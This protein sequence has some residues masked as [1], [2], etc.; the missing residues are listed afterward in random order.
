MA[1]A[2]IESIFN[3]HIKPDAEGMTAEEFVQMATHRKLLDGRRLTRT[4][5]LLIF[6][7]VKLGPKKRA[8]DLERF[9]EGFRQICKP[10]PVSGSLRKEAWRKERRLRRRERRG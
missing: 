8:I 7:R 4:E 9:I 1:L 10:R 2:A 6:E 5:C 3:A